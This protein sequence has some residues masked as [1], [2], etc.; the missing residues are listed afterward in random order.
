MKFSEE[1]LTKIEELK[2]RYQTTKALTLPVLWMAQK[3]FGWISGE[4]MQYV[5]DLLGLPVSH[6]YGVVT[7]YTMYNSKPVG[8]YHLQV[9]TN[10]SCQLLGA[11]E[12][13]DH[14]C[15]KLNVKL[16]ETTK[17]EKFTI[18]EVECL[19]SCGT[20]PAM[21]LNDDYVENLTIEKVDKLLTELK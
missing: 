3:E 1:N 4:T 9:C 8:K 18:V 16:G 5:A 19:G 21:Q 15:Q 2:K 17:D 10:I 11:E 12:L 6:V 14:I 7:F 13:R 20:A